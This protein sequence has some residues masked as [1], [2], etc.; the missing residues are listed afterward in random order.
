M[1]WQ[2]AGK[3]RVD[4]LPLL[5]SNG[6]DV[7][8]SFQDVTPLTAAVGKGA[9][10]AAAWLLDHGADV[11]GRASDD[12]V[13]P[14]H[15]AID[16]G[17]LEFVKFLLDRGADPDI[18]VG[19]PAR[20]AVAAARFWG[21]EEIATYLESRGY[22]D[23]AVPE[24]EPVDVEHESFRSRDEAN[25]EEW[26]QK[27]WWQV[28]DYGTRRGFESLGPR[29][30]VFF[31]V[32]YLVDQ[33]LSG[34]V[35]SFYANPSAGYVV[36]TPEAL[37][38]IRAERAAALVRKMNALFPGGAPAGDLEARA[39]QLSALP[40]RFAKLEKELERLVAERRGKPARNA[41][42]TQLYEY[43]HR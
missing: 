38:V 18:M 33:V 17:N 1:L 39:R 35:G 37:E 19:N 43:Y 31:L 30:R 13:S 2:A 41:M 28:Y 14:L 5:L 12:D 7:N 20:N 25:P 8:S 16:D 9:F 29:N 26:F 3:N 32:G 21:H 15:R 34:G 27:K 4:L 23:C 10:K 42:L 11:N 22:A 6:A 24:P 40:G 36:Q